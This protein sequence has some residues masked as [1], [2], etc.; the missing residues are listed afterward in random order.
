MFSVISSPFLLTALHG[1]RDEFPIQ[2]RHCNALA[3]EHS[4]RLVSMD[5]ASCLSISQV[6][7][8]SGMRTHQWRHIADEPTT[9]E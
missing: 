3:I 5:S 4:S 7:H 2:A 6:M 9:D 1:V 8:V